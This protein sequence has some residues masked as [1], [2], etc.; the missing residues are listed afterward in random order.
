MGSRLTWV[1]VTPGRGVLAESWEREGSSCGWKSQRTGAWGSG[2][3]ARLG[4]GSHGEEGLGGS[5]LSLTSLWLSWSWGCIED[6]GDPQCQGLVGPH[7]ALG[8]LGTV[9][10]RPWAAAGL[11]G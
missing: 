2:H 5:E 6:M 9:Q 10:R 4:C 11:Q 1:E 8:H 7:M 3:R